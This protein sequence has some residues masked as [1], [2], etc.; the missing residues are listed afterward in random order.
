MHHNPSICTSPLKRRYDVL[1]NTIFPIQDV[2]YR[3]FVA[4]E[5]KGGLLARWMLP[6]APKGRKA[7][8]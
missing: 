6:L 8:V 1:A 4:V 5:K 3:V 2:H 7:S